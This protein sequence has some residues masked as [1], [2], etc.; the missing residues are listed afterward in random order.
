MVGILWQSE[1]VKRAVMVG[2][3]WHIY[4]VPTIQPASVFVGWRGVTER[5]NRRRVVSAGN[6]AR[7]MP[8]EKGREEKRGAARLAV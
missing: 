5:P 3:L 2:I 8:E 6:R 7:R 4:V 1:R